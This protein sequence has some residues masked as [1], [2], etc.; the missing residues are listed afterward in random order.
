[1]AQIVTSQRGP[2]TGTA[3]AKKKR[4]PFLLDLYS[5]AVGKKYVMGATGIA[6]MGFPH[7]WEPEDV[8]RC[9]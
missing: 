6:M 3:T 9:S 2:V 4:R 5:T 1:M 7:D 8:R